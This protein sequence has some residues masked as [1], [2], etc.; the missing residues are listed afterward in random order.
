MIKEKERRLREEEE[1]RRIVKEK[2]ESLKEKFEEREHGEGREGGR[3]YITKKEM[4]NGN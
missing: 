3:E 2:E 4:R 1:R